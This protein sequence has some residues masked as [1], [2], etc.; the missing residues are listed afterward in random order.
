VSIAGAPLR[1]QGFVHIKA[2][3]EN[4]RLVLGSRTLALDGIEPASWLSHPIDGV[5][6][7]YA[8]ATPIRPAGPGDAGLAVVGGW[9]F[10]LIERF[11]EQAF[12]RRP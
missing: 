1:T 4:G 9:G 12:V 10:K 7:V 2:I 5:K 8:G 11:A 6:W 3:R